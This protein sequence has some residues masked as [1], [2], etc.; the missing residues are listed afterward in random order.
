MSRL[1]AFAATVACGVV[2]LSLDAAGDS[3][4]RIAEKGEIVI[5]VNTGFQPFGYIDNSGNPVGFEIDLAKSVADWLGVPPRLQTVAAGNRV[6]WLKAGRIDMILASMPVTQ[7]RRAEIGVIDPPYYASGIA[8]L[9]PAKL[10]L[11]A[12]AELKGRPVCGLSGAS[13]NRR[14]VEVY[15]AN[16]VPYASTAEIE[17]AL[18]DG[19][20]Q[21]WVFDETTLAA[22]LTRGERWSGFELPL[23]SEEPWTW[24]IGV[25]L[26]ER[27]GPYG[28]LISGIVTDWHRSGKLIELQ[29]R[30]GLRPSAFL[31]EQHRRYR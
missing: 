4:T 6:P 25:P 7:A 24:G 8:V 2:A 31:E 9:A 1:L 10:G 11:K 15:G 26:D 16:L 3:L 19:R 29:R 22:R 12:W 21:A 28:K 14:A 30:W 13:F 5:G 23:P 18:L 20:C 17:S 27:N